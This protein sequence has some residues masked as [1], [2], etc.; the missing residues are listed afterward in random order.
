MPGRTEQVDDL[1]DG[2]GVGGGLVV[3]VN[4]GNRNASPA[5][6]RNRPQ[7]AVWCGDMVSSAAST[8]TTTAG[9]NHTSACQR[10]STRAGRWARARW[11]RRAGRAASSASEKPVPH[12]QMVW[13]RS[14]SGS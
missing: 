13:N 7:P 4:R 5:S 6:S 9:S 12:L 3:A 11:A 8:S 2:G 10:E 14:P 1:A